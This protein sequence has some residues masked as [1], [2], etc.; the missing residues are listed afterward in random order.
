[1]LSKRVNDYSNVKCTIA[2]RNNYFINTNKT[3]TSRL[4]IQGVAEKVAELNGHILLVIRVEKCYTSVNCKILLFQD[5]F[6]SC[7]R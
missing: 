5:V 1:M 6:N 3:V 2:Y 7:P 4:T